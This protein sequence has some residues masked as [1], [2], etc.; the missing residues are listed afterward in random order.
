MFGRHQAVVLARC[1]MH[2]SSSAGE[3]QMIFVR[4][5]AALVW[6]GTMTILRRHVLSSAYCVYVDSSN[7]RYAFRCSGGRH[8]AAM[9]CRPNVNIHEWGHHAAMLSDNLQKV[10]SQQTCSWSFGVLNAAPNIPGCSGATAPPSQ[11]RWLRS[12]C[13]CRCACDC[14]DEGAFARMSAHVGLHVNG[15]GND[16]ATY[17]DVSETPLHL[18]EGVGYEGACIQIRWLCGIPNGRCKNDRRGFRSWR[19]WR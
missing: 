16:G 7:R 11:K 18:L 10:S 12:W 1:T 6:A 4:G 8:R 3:G 19:R 15:A 2:S 5:S 13:C 17:R 9:I 14:S